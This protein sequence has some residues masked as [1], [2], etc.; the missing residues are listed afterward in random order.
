MELKRVIRLDNIPL[1]RAYFTDEGYLIDNPICTSTGIFEYQNPDGTIRRE[2]RLPE[3]VF[4]EPSLASYEGK[5][6]IITHDAGLITAENEPQAGIGTILSKGYRDGD[7][8]RAKIVIHDTN[9]M[10]QAGL[11]ELSLGYDLR[12]DETPGVWRGQHYDA[13][14]RD[15][16][17]NHLA[18][19]R[20][21]RAGETARLNIDSRDGQ[22]RT[23]GK[24]MNTENKQTGTAQLTPEEIA[25][26]LAQ[27]IAQKAAK[28]KTV[29]ENTDEGSAAGPASKENPA[30]GQQD[31]PTDILTAITRRHQSSTLPKDQRDDDIEE[32][33]KLLSAKQAKED[34]T[35]SS[36]ESPENEDEAE[37]Q[38]ADKNN[39]SCADGEDQPPA[40]EEPGQRKKEPAVNMDA[41]DAMIADRLDL[42]RIAERLHMD[43]LASMPMKAAKK[44]VIAAVRPNI[45]L[46]GRDDSYIGA[47][48]DAAKDEI[49]RRKDIGFQRRQMAGSRLDEADKKADGS[50]AQTARDRMI[51]N[52]KGDC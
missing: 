35:A 20:R 5:P 4:S 6:V 40:A 39:T 8:V 36:P 23:G 22:T 27:A 47:M 21:A 31:N 50:K 15:I 7:Y 41:L 14:Q 24:S 28:A 44:A 48:F 38:P 13:V 46:D 49:L 2:L 17:I 51:Q 3:E 19:V 11:K 37:K 26:A 33:L 18:L 16:R 42:I 1:S 30:S 34:F 25:A 29:P 43:G 10:K 32:L 45:R 52:M 9:A 12:L